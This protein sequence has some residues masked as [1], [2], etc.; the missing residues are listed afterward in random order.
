[1]LR[2]SA[3]Q[4][5]FTL[6]E[7]LVVI[8]IIAIL[9]AILFP[10][11]AKARE[12]ARQASCSSNLKQLALSWLMYNQDYDG[13]A[14]A[15]CFGVSDTCWDRRQI[16]AGGCLGPYIKNTQIL[17]C[18]SVGPVSDTTASGYNYNREVGWN[19]PK[20]EAQIE[21]PAITLAF[22][23]GNG[24][25][26]MPYATTCCSNTAT[27]FGMKPNHNSGTNL[28]FCDGHVKWYNLSSIPDN[29]SATTPL[30]VRPAP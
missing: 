16:G 21:Q 7:L 9:A 20:S 1:M 17:F 13:R 12:K 29:D 25:R 19:P 15:A 24:L 27:H 3:R 11:F 26:W 5:G 30:R 8:A 4:H 2:S 22:G 18:P 6:I 10:V 23:E 28:A 14:M